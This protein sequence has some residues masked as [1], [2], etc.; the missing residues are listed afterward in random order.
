MTSASSWIPENP[1]ST[2][3]DIVVVG[4]GVGG[5]TVGVSL[6]KQ[7]HR[8]LFIEKGNF[9][10]GDY[11]RGDGTKP[12]QTDNS[13]E[14]RLRTGWWP[15]QISGQYEGREL[16]LFAPLGCGTGGSSSLYAAQLER[17]SP[18]DFECGKTW[19]SVPGASIPE[20][21]PI[22]YDELAPYYRKAESL[23]RVCGTED[24]LQ[25]DPEANLA[26]PPPLSDRD[27]H[28]FNSFEEL[29]LHPFRAHVGCRFVEGCGECGGS[30]CP[31]AC[32]SDAGQVALV[33]AVMQHGAKILPNCEV[34]KLEADD[35]RVTGVR[36]RRGDEESVVRGKIVI[37]AASAYMTPTLLLKSASD[38]WPN[39]LANS[40][41][42]VGKNLMMHTGDFIAIRAGKSLSG[43]GPKKALA[44]NDFYTDKGRKLG[45]LQSVGIQVAPGYVLYH[46]RNRVERER[47]WYLQLARPFFRII[48]YIAAA[49]YK[50]AS[51]FSSIVEDLPYEHNQ[52]RYDPDAEDGMTFEYH[53]SDELL[54]RNRLF[55]KCVADTIG[56]RHSTQVLNTDDNLNFG[57][58]CGTTRF[59]DD[60]QK[61]VLDR[62]NRAHDV[63]NL[64][65]V[66]ASFFPTSGGN[67][68]SLTI[69]ANAL[70]VADEIGK[71]LGSSA[72]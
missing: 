44:L 48:S 18:L 28:L 56:K 51:V 62:N 9:L 17:L 43:E 23:Y 26:E 41:G 39:G 54:E 7:G 67:N 8:V 35:T 25:P 61:S 13:P 50:S 47:T 1:E 55:R 11:D 63:E 71:E 49:F 72:R 12:I 66:D 70:R 10:F 64:Y 3:W 36:F 38:Q 45:T 14:A 20:R 30:L 40:S 27:A 4:T 31:N 32:K 46:L 68:P 53:Y 34:I 65:V 2:E 37:V 16:T 33:P 58:V 57:H 59:G 69:A 29:G 42:L 24:P 19:G 21:W 22:S 60:P 5:S 52:I 6:A 15:N